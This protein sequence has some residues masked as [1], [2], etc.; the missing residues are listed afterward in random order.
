[1]AMIS[2]WDIGIK[3]QSVLEKQVNMLLPPLFP[4]NRSISGS[5]LR[6]TLNTLKKITDFDIIEIPSGTKCFDWTIPEEWN[7]KEAYI[8]DLKGEKIIDFKKNNLHLVNYSTAQDNIYTFDQL[9]KHLHTLPNMPDAI[10]YRT[11]YYQKSWGFCFAYD[12]LKKFKK[13]QKYHVKIDASFR[14]GSITMGE[15]KICGKSKKTF[16]ITTYACHPSMAND[17]LSGLILWILLLKTLSS[18][19]THYSYK[20]IIGPETIG[21]IA[22]LSKN[23]KL[24]KDVIGGFVLATLGGSGKFGYKQTYLGDHLIDS[25]IKKSF[26]DLNV[27]FIT[28]PFDLNGS[29]ER[30]YSSPFF[31]IPMASVTK[32]KY[33]EYPAY[34]TS[35]DDLSFVKSSHIISSLKIYLKIIENLENSKIYISTQPKCEPMLSKRGLYPKIGGSFNPKGIKGNTIYG[36]D[37]KEINTIRALLFWSDGESSLEQISQKTGVPITRL[38]EATKKLENINLLKEVK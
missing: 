14:N 20:F 6:K 5:G 18:R 27:D 25:V 11:S 22:F 2:D 12:D 32:D 1:M 23:K 33:Y 19:K 30:Q 34:H 7:V 8:E 21:A 38:F 3:A 35:K 26:K 16:L 15:K 36:Y 31:R 13:T 17:N 4:L 24:L 37:V 9:K 29:D 10:P 28:Y